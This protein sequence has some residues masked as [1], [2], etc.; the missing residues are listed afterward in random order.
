VAWFSVSIETRSD[1]AP[2]MTEDEFS[3]RLGDLVNALVPYS[4]VVAGGG[5]PVRWGATI[6]VE[7]TTAVTAI[8]EASTIIRRAGSDVFL[9]DWP[10]VRAEA[11]REDVLDEELGQRPVHA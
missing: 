8:T 1:D 6:S 3:D 9:P 11:V 2:S 5:E 4:G 7:S 10:I